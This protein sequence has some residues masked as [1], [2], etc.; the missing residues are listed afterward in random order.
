MISAEP[1]SEKK[2]NFLHERS[3]PSARQVRQV[4]FYPN[5][6]S[7]TQAYSLALS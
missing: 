6:H 1:H 7:R 2:L 5:L 3:I 4:Y